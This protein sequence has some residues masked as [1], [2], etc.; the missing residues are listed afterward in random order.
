MGYKVIKNQNTY[1]IIKEKGGYNITTTGNLIN[2][3]GVL[4]GFSSS[5][6]ATIQINFNPTLNYS[7]E[8]Y[9]E[10]KTG[11]DTIP[12]YSEIFC[13]ACFF[14][15]FDNGQLM[16]TVRTNGNY[17]A[18]TSGLSALNNTG[19]LTRVRYFPQTTSKDGYTYNGGYIYVEGSTDGGV[20]WSRGSY[21]MTANLDTL[22][23]PMGLGSTPAGAE[24]F[25]GSI[26]LN[27][28]YIKINDV[29]VW[30]G[31]KTTYKVIDDN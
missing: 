4:S 3:N 31:E 14:L 22:G 18:F 28:C 12:Q 17:Y 8:V 26:D 7:F 16:C 25:A 24:P 15:R 21:R 10:V 6:Y 13:N 20:N 9:A 29:K 23:F 19:Y 27:E 5:N 1:K 2:N 11:S 30:T